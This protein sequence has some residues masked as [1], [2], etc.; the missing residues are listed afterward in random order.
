MKLS[1][2]GCRSQACTR[3]APASAPSALLAARTC[4]AK[5]VPWLS[6]AMWR[7]RPLISLPPWKPAL[8]ALG[9]AFDALAI[10]DGGLGRAPGA[11]QLHLAPAHS[12]HD[13]RLLPHRALFPAS[14]VVKH[15]VPGWK[16]VRQG[17]PA[18]ALAQPVQTRFDRTSLEVLLARAAR[19]GPCKEL[20]DL[21]PLCVAQIA[22]IAHATNLPVS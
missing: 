18:A 11:A 13:D 14:P 15:R 17:P 6:T 12:Q 20:F 1:M 21:L 5:S 10:E 22:W 3:T 4:T 8:L 16:V 19:I 7:E 2:E 9:G